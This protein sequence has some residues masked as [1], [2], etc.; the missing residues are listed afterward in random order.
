MTADGAV[1]GMD[2]GG[3]TI[4]VDLVDLAGRSLFTSS[5]P[6]GRGQEALE[7][8]H[9]QLAAAQKAARRAGVQVLGVGML[10]PGHVDDVRGVVRFASNL[11]W[12]DLELQ[13]QAAAAMDGSAPV[14]VG[15]DVRWAGIA[16]GVLG[17]ATGLSDYALVSIGTGIA[18]CLVSGG[19]VLAGAAGSA[20]EF[21]HATVAPGGDRC[22]CGRIGCTDAYASGAALLR[23]YR[24]LGGERD[25]RDVPTLLGVLAEDPVAAQV[26]DDGLEA[27]ARGL[28]TLTLTLDPGTIVFAGGLSGAGTALTGPLRSRLDAQ[29]LWK[30]TPELLI[31]PLGNSTGRAGAVLLALTAAEQRDQALTWDA[32]TVRRWGHAEGRTEVPA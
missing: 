10:S 3:T 29:L 21:G 24:A 32:S 15:Q 9:A 20:G 5:R 14:A 22:A 18:A 12:H 31:S 1:I 7:S 23:R 19:N 28:C 16:E 27:L 8:V 6:T 4:S 30:S 13:R 17:A 11:E 25:L 26:W 2:I